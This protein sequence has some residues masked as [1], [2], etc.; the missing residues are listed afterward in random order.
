MDSEEVIADLFLSNSRRSSAICNCCQLQAGHIK[1]QEECRKLLQNCFATLAPL[2]ASHMAATE[3]DDHYQWDWMNALCLLLKRRI[4]ELISSLLFL[5]ANPLILHSWLH[6]LLHARL[7]A[8]QSRI[9]S[10]L[11]IMWPSYYSKS[12]LSEEMCL[13]FVLFLTIITLQYFCAVF[14]SSCCDA[15]LVCKRKSFLIFL[16][17]VQILMVSVSRQGMMYYRQWTVLQLQRIHKVWVT[18]EEVWCEKIDHISACWLQ[19]CHNTSV[20]AH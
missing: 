10:L 4:F 13:M 20:L 3:R 17:T 5:Q 12:P 8:Q 15:V 9:R 2:I 18:P 16:C 6:C 14:S 1:K 11:S 19:L 7:L